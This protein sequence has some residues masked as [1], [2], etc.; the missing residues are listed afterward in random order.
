MQGYNCDDIGVWEALDSYPIHL[1][2]YFRDPEDNCLWFELNCDDQFI[3]KLIIAH[4]TAGIPLFYAFFRFFILRVWSSSVLRPCFQ[5]FLKLNIFLQ[6]L[7]YLRRKF[8]VP[9]SYCHCMKWS[10][11]SSNFSP[12]PMMHDRTA[13]LLFSTCSVEQYYVPQITTLVNVNGAGTSQSFT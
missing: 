13:I 5:L 2:I 6:H 11:S 12:E 1:F 3:N 7:N 10:L 9:F 4:Y 8:S